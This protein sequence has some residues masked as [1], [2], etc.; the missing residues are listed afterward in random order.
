MLMIHILRFA[1]PPENSET[2]VLNSSACSDHATKPRIIYGA[3]LRFSSVCP[4]SEFGL[5]AYTVMYCTCEAPGIRYQP[6]VPGTRYM[7]PGTLVKQFRKHLPKSRFVDMG[8]DPQ[9]AQR[10][11]YLPN[12]VNTLSP[13][14]GRG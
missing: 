4:L 11:G 1:S 14:A 6:T 7:V 2:S 8:G 12:S 3:R 5:T 13:C 9:P 10:G